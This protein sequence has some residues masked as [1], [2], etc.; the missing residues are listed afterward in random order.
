MVRVQYRLLCFLKFKRKPSLQDLAILNDGF[1]TDH[2]FLKLR[3]LPCSRIHS[4]I[5]ITNFALQSKRT[6]I[7]VFSPTDNV[8]AN[9]FTG[10]GNE[11]EFWILLSQLPRPLGSVDDISVANVVIKMAYAFVESNDA[12]QRHGAFDGNGWLRC[13]RAIQD[14]T[15]QPPFADCL[16]D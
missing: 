12:L 16:H 10:S 9:H 3:G 1:Q 5:E 7:R 13:G 11:F 4:G 6:V 8:P 2:L 14:Q 15:V